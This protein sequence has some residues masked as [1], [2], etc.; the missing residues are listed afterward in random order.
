MPDPI[1]HARQFVQSAFN[2]MGVHDAIEET[3]L[4]RDGQ[5][6]GHRF[7]SGKISAVW[8]LEESEVKIF[9]ANRQLLCVESLTSESELRRAA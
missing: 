3:A 6:C 8:F 5:Y 7:Q 2:R 9:G 1:Q 4:I